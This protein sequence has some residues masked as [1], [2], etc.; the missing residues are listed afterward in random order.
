MC[1]CCL[2]L[3]VIPLYSFSQQKQPNFIFI[4][5]DDQRFDGLGANGNKLISTPALDKLAEQS[6]RFTNAHV[7]FS[8]CSPSR[9][10][11]LTGRYGSANGVLQL[12]SD[13]NPDE[14]TIAQV[15]QENGYATAISGKWHL[16]RKPV[17]AGFNFSV[18]FEGNG[19]YYGRT[20]HDQEKTVE[21]TEH[22]DLYCARRSVD[23][24]KDAVESDQ[25]FFLFH[26]TQLPHMNGQLEWNARPETLSEYQET[27]MPVPV[28]RLDNLT[29]K[30]DYLENVRNL[31]QAKVYGYPE[32]SAIQ[33]HTKEYYAVITEMSEFLNVLLNSV[34]ELGIRDNTYIFFM[35]DNGWMLGEHG[36]TSKVLPYQPSTHVPL[37]IAGP[38]IKPGKED[39]LALNIDV[40]STILEM[41]DIPVP[42]NIHGK[43]LLPLMNNAKTTWRKSFVYEG[44]G[45]YGGAQPNLS[46]VSEQYKYIV[47]YNNPDLK[48]KSYVELYNLADD[49]HERN[50]I[51]ENKQYKNQI[52]K[53]DRII[54]D[55]HQAVLSVTDYYNN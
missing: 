29:G 55:H 54:E 39:R 1:W 3:Q 21:P 4:C 24:L 36:L 5:S 17:D 8:L 35:S 11:L 46:V 51:A 42:V 6:I 14:K 12:G 19:T 26:N 9:A 23:F 53:F 47:T 7:V 44:L 32:K 28:S 48:E 22:C 18:W 25:P 45:T 10:A 49:P 40:F 20:L 27:D 16:G 41:A 2:V 33:K 37:L 38:G 31:T 30:P 50:N 34:D 43:S 13:L 52:Q 15:L